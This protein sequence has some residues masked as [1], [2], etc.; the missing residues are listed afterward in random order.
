MYAYVK[1]VELLARR[2]H[3]GGSSVLL[4]HRPPVL[5]GP[6]AAV[7]AVPRRGARGRLQPPRHGPDDRLVERPRHRPRLGPG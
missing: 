1:P 7:A 4:R 3:E 6:R 5:A 2:H